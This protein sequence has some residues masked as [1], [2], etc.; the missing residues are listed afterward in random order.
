M[1]VRMRRVLSHGFETTFETDLDGSYFSSASSVGSFFVA[2]VP[3]SSG[4]HDSYT[5]AD[6]PNPTTSLFALT[7]P[8]GDLESL[9]SKDRHLP[10]QR[11]DRDQRMSS[12]V[13]EVFEHL[14]RDVRTGFGRVLQRHSEIVM[15]E[16]RDVIG[17]GFAFGG[18]GRGDVGF[19][20]DVEGVDGDWDSVRT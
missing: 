2:R 15:R 20:W 11:R 17:F 3:F 14:E 1:W 10:S 6:V 8:H 19:G 9:F 7:Y 13:V 4:G 18:G 12:V 16:V 5:L